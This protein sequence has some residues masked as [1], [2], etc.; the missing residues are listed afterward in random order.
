VGTGFSLCSCL[1]A[2]CQHCYYHLSALIIRWIA[3]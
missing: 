1:L 3:I 2:N